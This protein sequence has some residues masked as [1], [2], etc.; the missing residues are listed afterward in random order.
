MLCLFFWVW[1]RTIKHGNRFFLKTKS[2]LKTKKKFLPLHFCYI[3]A[4]NKKAGSFFQSG[5]KL[6]CPKN[7]RIL[8]FSW[9]KLHAQCLKKLDSAQIFCILVSPV[10]HC[11]LRKDSV[12]KTSA[13]QPNK[14]YVAVS[15]FACFSWQSQQVTRSKGYLNYF[16]YDN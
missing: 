8:T 12:C 16:P 5:V 4:L 7:R 11:V 3:L 10:P 2:I 9:S 14:M 1:R 13:K 15:S 6:F